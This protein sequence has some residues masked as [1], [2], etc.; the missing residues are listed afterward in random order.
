MSPVIVDPVILA[1]G[2]TSGKVTMLLVVT[3][4][5]TLNKAYDAVED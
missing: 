2:D 1:T 3:N 5:G 4:A